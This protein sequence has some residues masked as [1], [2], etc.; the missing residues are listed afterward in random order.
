MTA[1]VL[2]QFGYYGLPEQRLPSDVRRAAKLNERQDGGHPGERLRA[3]NAF[4]A[5]AAQK[6]Q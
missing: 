2:V 1:V 4:K 3:L 5:K 6:R